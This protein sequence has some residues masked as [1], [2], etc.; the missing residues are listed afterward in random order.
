MVSSHGVIQ[1]YNATAMVDEK[2][3]VI[4]YAE[5]FG[6]N[7]DSQ[8][9]RPMLEGAE[10]IRHIIVH[11]G[12]RASQ[13]FINRT[14]RNDLAVGEIVPVTAEYVGDVSSS[15]RLLASELFTKVSKK[16]FQVGESDLD[17]VW[18]LSESQGQ[19]SDG[20]A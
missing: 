7:E 13:E 12:G 4:A 19:V 11:N 6:E 3:Q 17:G 8:H 10:N 20:G 5:A 15:S 1:G 14:G 2:H 16:F 9:T 18:R